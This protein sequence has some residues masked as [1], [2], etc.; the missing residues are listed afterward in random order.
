MLT[1]VSQINIDWAGQAVERVSGMKLDEYFK[2]HIFDKLDIKST[3][4]LPDKDMLDNMVTAQQRRA[5]GSVI[6]V[7]HPFRRPLWLSEHPQHKN[8]MFQAGGAG[9]FSKPSDYCSMSSL[10]AR[11]RAVSKPL[12][13]P[14]PR[15]LWL[16]QY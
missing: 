6:P 14:V 16:H 12:A 1:Q 4:F 11:V 15:S 7:D 9:C 10:P 5:D 8:T 3:T 13:R 2:R